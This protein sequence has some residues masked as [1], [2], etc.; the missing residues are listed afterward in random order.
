MTGMDEDIP[1]Y[2]K[3][4]ASMK[5]KDIQSFMY[6]ASSSRFWMLRKQINSISWTNF[7][8]NKVPFF[9]WQCISILTKDRDVDLVIESEKDMIN[10]LTLLIYKLE[11]IDGYRGTAI[12]HVKDFGF[13]NAIKTYK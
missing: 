1:V 5:L 3:S 7:N 9:A 2:K 4:R 12:P 11:T 6:G 13:H 10:L 8:R